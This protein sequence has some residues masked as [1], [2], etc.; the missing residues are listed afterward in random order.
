MTKAKQVMEKIAVSNAWLGKKL[1]QS[2]LSMLDRIGYS[3]GMSDKAVETLLTHRDKTW[4]NLRKVMGPERFEAVHREMDKV[5]GP[6][7]HRRNMEMN[8]K[9]ALTPFTT[10][11]TPTEQKD[12]DTFWNQFKYEERGVMPRN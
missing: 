8:D 11:I 7:L 5:T 9:K 10:K 2:Y 12:H 3:K 1:G 4:R 6:A